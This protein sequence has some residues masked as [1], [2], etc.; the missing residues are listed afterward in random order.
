MRL[1]DDPHLEFRVDKFEK[2][3]E[4]EHP[5]L[6]PTMD[7]G[8]AVLARQELREVIKRQ[9]LSLERNSRLY[10]E[11]NTRILTQIHGRLG[12]HSTPHSRPL[13]SDFGSTQ[14]SSVVKR[15]TS[16]IA[17]LTPII[18][19]VRRGRSKVRDDD[20]DD[21]EPDVRPRELINNINKQ[22]ESGAT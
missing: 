3:P 2:L 22:L 11:L 10:R 19:G 20:S 18:G 14:A 8:S 15:M 9:R 13:P 1:S 12:A 21:S 4:P 7:R 17:K 16:Y 5:L 6:G